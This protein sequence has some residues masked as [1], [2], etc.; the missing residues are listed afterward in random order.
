VSCSD[1]SLSSHEQESFNGL[2]DIEYGFG[3]GGGP[4]CGHLF[5]PLFDAVAAHFL[6]STL[7]PVCFFNERLVF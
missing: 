1:I 2:S 5:A 6:S 4:D 3:G 7:G